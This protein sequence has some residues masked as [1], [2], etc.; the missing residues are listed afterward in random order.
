MEVRAGEVVLA[1]GEIVPAELIV[2]A[3]GIK[4]PDFLRDLDGLETD[5][6]NRLVVRPTLQTTRDDDVFAIG[7]CADCILPGDNRAAAAAGAGR[8]SAGRLHGRSHQGPPARRAAAGISNI[9]ISARWWRSRDYGTLGVLFQN[10]KMQG[11]LARLD[12]SVAAQAASAGAARQLQSRAGY[13]GQC[14]DARAPSRGSNALRPRAQLCSA[15]SWCHASSRRRISAM[16]LI[17][18]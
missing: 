4:A 7:D 5:K 9:A 2:W 16:A 3:A 11:L 6:I 1:S 10:V 18:T 8:A 13:A 14:A 17:S 12:L 15:V